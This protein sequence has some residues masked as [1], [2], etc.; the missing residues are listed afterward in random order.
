MRVKCGDIEV[1]TRWGN[2]AK[3]VLDPWV[4]KEAYGGSATKVVLERNPFFWQVDKEGKQLPYIDRVQ[5]SIISE[6]ET[7]VLA[8]INGQ[9]DF[10]HRHVFPDPEPPDPG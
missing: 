8:A 2:P 1:P 6:V 5:F 7:I 9:L 10:Q 4:I 3:P